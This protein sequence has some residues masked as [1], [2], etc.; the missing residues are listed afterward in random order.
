MPKIEAL[1]GAPIEWHF[2]GPVQSN[3]TRAIARY[4]AWVHGIDR[5]KIAQRLSAQRPDDLAP[6]NAC[7]QV[8]LS[9]EDSKAG[10]S[11][12]ETAVLARAVAAL[13]GLR[14]RG[15]MTLPAM[16]DDFDTQRAAFRRLRELYEALVTEGLALD[17][18]SMGM[19]GD[20]EAAVAEG[21]TLVRIGTGIFGS[22]A[23][24]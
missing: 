15:L 20:L 2:V 7:I 10:A 22:R 24:R 21:S 19:T 23:P 8:N 18:L 12:A 9:R 13:P 4:F 6:L 3:K 11:P 17:T 1:A 14:V 16:S 5:L